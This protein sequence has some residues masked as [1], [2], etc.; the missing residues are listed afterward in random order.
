MSGSA[1]SL[2]L[3]LSVVATLGLTGC[4]SRSS[5]EA[6]LTG[7]GHAS[8]SVTTPSG[9]PIELSGFDAFVDTQM[10]ELNIPGL[11]IAV[12]SDGEIVYD[13]AKGVA[14]LDTGEPITRASVFEAA[15]LSKPVFAYFVLK[16]ADQ[17]LLDIDRPLYEYR[18]LEG[19]END[20]RYHVVTTRM[21]LSHRTGF[22]NW[23]WF[24]PAPPESMIERG[25][26]YMKREPGEFGYSGEGYNYVSLVVADLTG[27]D[28][29]TLDSVYQREVAEPLGLSCSAF[30]RTEC[31]AAR[32]VTGH[33]D[34]RVVEAQW[35]RS[36]PDDT[37]M[38]F[39]AAGRLH[40]NAL[41]YARIMI[42]MMNEE[43]LSG[44]LFD[45]FYAA[46]A[47]V[48]L[49]SDTH[50]ATGV[51]AWGLGVAIEPTEFGTRYEHG[52]NNG[53]FQSGM[54]FFK[55]LK[56]GYVFLTNSDRGEEFNRRLEACITS[57]ACQ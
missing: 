3:L 39:G 45:E 33:R 49:D 4:S 23:R 34:G 48:P 19:L 25:T 14:N 17:G 28:Q 42:A 35:P 2:P 57:A 41:D 9:M 21:A 38:T 56:V 13:A 43:G 40:T 16:L 54:M 8:D 5:L 22:P 11:S 27:T 51:T 55:D 46:Q 20:N 10:R 26:M 7:T 53:D 12:I 18:P 44:S 1:N 52:G 6:S 29:L 24:D 36:F 30:V 47:E 50:R 37:P 31:V 15:S 32:K